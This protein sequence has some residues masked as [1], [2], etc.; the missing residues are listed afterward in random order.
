[1]PVDVNKERANLTLISELSKTVF[2]KFFRY[3]MNDW[4]AKK[5]GRLNCQGTEKNLSAS[6]YKER[7]RR[8]DEIV[9]RSQLQ[10]I[11]EIVQLCYA[12]SDERGDEFPDIALAFSET[13]CYPPENDR[14]VR[15]E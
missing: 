9:F 7:F 5:G 10:L 12:T 1:M 14:G 2:D 6:L 8:L 15:F 13:L 11:D 3:F 4:V